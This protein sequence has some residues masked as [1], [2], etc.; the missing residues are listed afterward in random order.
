MNEP[1]SRKSNERALLITGGEVVD[2]EGRR[3]MKADVLL[4]GGVIRR[5]EPGLREKGAGGEDVELID[6]TGRLVTPGLVDMHVHL[7][8]PGFEYRETIE[9]GA[10]AAV[11]GGV[12]SVACMANTR[13]VNDCPSVTRFILDRAERA[14]LA[15]VLPIEADRAGSLR[16]SSAPQRTPRA[17]A[18][19]GPLVL[20]CPDI[21]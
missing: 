7:R 21:G 9:S 8:E 4:E 3:M 15:R 1:T 10:L 12:T 14:G 17:R 16:S 19:R 20:S 6:A 18:R 2:P 5:I 11:T 13:P